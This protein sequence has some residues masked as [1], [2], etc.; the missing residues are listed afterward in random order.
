MTIDEFIA[1]LIR[2]FPKS[3]DEI[4]AWVPDYRYALA[5]MSGEDLA[6]SLRG[7]LARWSKSWPPK[8]GEI[9]KRRAESTERAARHPLN[10]QPMDLFGRPFGNGRDIPDLTDEQFRMWQ[11]QNG[12][13]FMAR[14][15]FWNRMRGWMGDY[16]AAAVLKQARNEDEVYRLYAQWR[17]GEAFDVNRQPKASAAVPVIVE[18]V[19]DARRIPE[20]ADA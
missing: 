8:P 6:E 17:N 13:L 2:R 11:F 12:Q 1:A 20:L 10:V 3:A 19:A 18:A 5:G 4:T 7:T 16:E 15:P 9:M 14:L